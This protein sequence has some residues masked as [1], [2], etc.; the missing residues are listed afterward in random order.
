MSLLDIVG[1]VFYQIYDYF[2]YITKVDE[3]SK[4]VVPVAKGE[5]KDIFGSDEPVLDLIANVFSDKVL[6]L[7]DDFAKEALD[8]HNI[9]RAK[10]HA[11][12]L[13]YSRELQTIAQSWL[14]TLVV[15]DR[16]QHSYNHRANGEALGENIVVLWSNYGSPLSGTNA[17]LQW[18]NEYPMHNYAGQYQQPTGHFTQ[19]IWASTTHMGIAKA[20]GPSGKWFG[21]ANYYPMGNIVDKEN[22]FNEFIMK[23]NPSKKLDEYL[24]QQSSIRNQFEPTIPD[25]N[26]NN[27]NKLI[28]QQFLLKRNERPSKIII[29]DDFRRR[30]DSSSI[31]GRIV[32]RTNL[33]D[34]NRS[35]FDDALTKRTNR[36]IL[37]NN[38]NQNKN[39]DSRTVSNAGTESPF[40]NSLDKTNNNRK[41]LDNTPVSRPTSPKFADHKSPKN[42]KKTEFEASEVC[43][44]SKDSEDICGMKNIIM[45]NFNETERFLK[46][47][48]NCCMPDMEDVGTGKAIPRAAEMELRRSIASNERLMHQYKQLKD[49]VDRSNDMARMYAGKMHM[50]FEIEK[51]K[52]FVEMRK[53]ECARLRGK[54]R[55]F[56]RLLA[57]NYAQIEK[58]K[59]TLAKL[60]EN[61]DKADHHIDELPGV[62]TTENKNKSEICQYRTE[63]LATK[64]MIDDELC[65]SLC[66]K[67]QQ[68]KQQLKKIGETLAE[69]QDET[70]KAY[71][72]IEK[73]NHKL[74]ESGDY[75]SQSTNPCRRNTPC[76]PAYALLQNQP[77]MPNC[78]NNTNYN[79]NNNNNY[80]FLYNINNSNDLD[81]MTNISTVDE[82]P[83]KKFEEQFTIENEEGQLKKIEDLIDDMQKILQISNS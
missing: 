28:Y 54:A 24:N 73:L 42:V 29:D 2:Q 55:F 7:N 46:T 43:E 66:S 48:T 25:D 40:G 8:L 27:C 59:S 52:V 71:K 23:E 39:T 56:Q 6:S 19:L 32:K 11:A 10:H 37:D 41:T 64:E 57:D 50:M 79:N 78:H 21:V 60:Q 65:L 18:Y 34:K 31:S 58:Y 62:T 49:K 45:M 80:S 51:L 3:Q 76:S 75:T 9:L 13:K 12:P 72:R 53:S 61:I 36:T 69:F 1:N 17:T 35:T 30:L 26:A 70:T 44:E 4:A 83:F 68:A 14:Q 20:Q 77:Q 38:Q 81:N 63:L 47:K 16:M 15:L 74:L 22:Y 67:E 5:Q 82:L 33:N